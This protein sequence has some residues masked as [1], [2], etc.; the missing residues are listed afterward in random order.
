[1]PDPVKMKKFWTVLLTIVSLLIGGGLFS[2]TAAAADNGA[3]FTIKPI[4][5]KNQLDSSL[6]YFQLKTKPGSTGKLGVT[7][8]N[9]DRS[10][11]RKIKVQP[12]VA[13]TSDDGQINYTPSNSKLDSSAQLE[14]PKLMSKA[15][16]VKL[17]PLTQRQV[18]FS[19]KIPD[20]GF[21][22]TLLGSIYALDE[23]ASNSKAKGF[24]INNRFAMALGVSMTT[25]PNWVVSPN[26][27]L[28]DVAARVVDN[29][30]AVVANLRNVAPT[31]FRGMN[32]KTD[33]TQKGESKKL[34]Q[35]RL[36]D[37][38]MAPTSNFNF[39][40]DTKGKAIPAGDYTLN[41]TVKV[42]KRTWHLTKDFTVTAADH[43]KIAAKIG[44]KQPNNWL[45]WLIGI[46]IILLLILL[47]WTFYRLGKKGGRKDD[48]PT[49]DKP[50]DH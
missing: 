42:G 7:V 34:Y 22:G 50:E 26:F 47:A 25:N 43:D 31:Y 13:T 24:T 16:T 5:P 9:L 11:S 20:A 27:E 45:Y 6:G 14:L 35:A 8:A 17:A 49:Q 33:V 30:P 19:Y 21:K 38:S 41:M 28:G 3:K 36:N 37:G 32:V 46:L 18:T 4:Y 1:M 44:E 39:R 23:T 15:V 40:V 10:Q 12:V 2:Q 29:Q 48:K